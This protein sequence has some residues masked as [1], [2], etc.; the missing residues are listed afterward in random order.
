M[1]QCHYMEKNRWLT[2]KFR[3]IMLS[4]IIAVAVLAAGFGVLYGGAH[5]NWPQNFSAG[6]FSPANAATN[7]FSKK[8][9]DPRLPNRLIIPSI[10]VNAA[11]Q[12][13]GLTPTGR[14]SIP[15]NFTDVAW[16]KL[17]PKP[18]EAGSAVIDGHL[19]TARDAN[20]V[21]AKLSE[22]KKGDLIEILD[23]A[24]Q[25]IKF[26]VIETAVYDETN[27]P[28][29]KIFD[30]S[31]TAARLNLITCDGVWNQKNRSYDKRFVVYSER[32][33]D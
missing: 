10:G 14:M 3:T 21:F 6:I 29:N 18:G 26:Q 1:L 16:Y 7:T 28:L 25:T 12:S 20:A 22:L 2:S 27:A 8:L 11:V 31:L 17:G 5:L 30:Q 24:K 32:V 4:F 15:N 33:N 9:I 13:V 19:D 23:Q